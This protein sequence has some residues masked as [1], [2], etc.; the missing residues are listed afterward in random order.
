[1][2]MEWVVDPGLRTVTEER[3]GRR[4]F[5]FEGRT[6]SANVSITGRNII[7]NSLL[8][9]TYKDLHEYKNRATL[10]VTTRFTPHVFTHGELTGLPWC[11]SFCM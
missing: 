6:S 7:P 4:C 10:D 2:L 3:G 1:M 9:T 8:P 5:G 11:T